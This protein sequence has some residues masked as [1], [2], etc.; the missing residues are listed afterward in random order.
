MK[1]ILLIE[2]NKDVRENT[3]E[4][5]SLSN[6]KVFTAEN[7]KAGVELAV[8]EHPDLIICD[9]MMPVMD[10]YSVLHSLSKNSETSSIPFIFLTAKTERSD[11]RK[12]MEM[13]ADDY[14]TKPFD[15]IELLNAVEARLAKSAALKRDFATSIEG[16]NEFISAAKK[17]QHLNL[18][19]DEHEVR[20]YKKRQLIYE[21]AG[22]PVCMFFVEKGKVKIFRTNDDGKELITSIFKE[23]EFFG[24]T[25]LF[26][27]SHYQDSAEALEDCEI[28]LIPK[29]EFF[30]LIGNDP[31]VAGRFIRMLAD[32]LSE[33]EEQLL[34]LA[35]NSVRKRVANSLLHV[36]SRYK[37]SDKDNPV[38]QFTR[39]D[40]ANVVGTATESLIRTLSDFKSEKLIDI[41]DGKISILNEEKL[42]KMVN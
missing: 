22:R 13:G 3:A 34:Q 16:F 35:Y 24:Y 2:D 21:S 39:E 1:S 18:L 30:E 12:G 36:Q 28:M 15:D 9:I 25:P 4:I 23:G 5:L 6:Y 38:L 19:S 20:N 37:K 11:L 29:E 26:E 42:R 10:G 31:S 14:I 33:R 17:V 41:K 8:Q 27:E 40:L 32:N 7:G